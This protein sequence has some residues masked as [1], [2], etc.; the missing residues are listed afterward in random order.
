MKLLKIGEVAEE[1]GVSVQTV[2]YYAKEVSI[3]P[4]VRSNS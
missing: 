1:A 4:A 2:R 3:S